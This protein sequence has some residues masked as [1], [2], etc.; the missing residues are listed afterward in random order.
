MIESKGS[1][2]LH[3]T[4]D[5]NK[6]YVISTNSSPHNGQCI[7]RVDCVYRMVPSTVHGLAGLNTVSLHGRSYHSH[8]ADELLRPKEVR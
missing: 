4:R 8:F 2:G 7:W 5:V 6:L 1:Q 3:C